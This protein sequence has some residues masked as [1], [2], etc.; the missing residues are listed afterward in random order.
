MCYVFCQLLCLSVR[1]VCAVVVACTIDGHL[2]WYGGSLADLYNPCG[3][4]L[5]SIVMRDLVCTL[6]LQYFAMIK[7]IIQLRQRFL[8]CAC[9]SAY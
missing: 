7:C 9:I 2:A 8:K 3:L 1:C 5:F 4:C 6:Y